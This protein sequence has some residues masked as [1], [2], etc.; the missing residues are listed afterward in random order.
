MK[1]ILFR[2]LGYSLSLIV[3]IVLLN[4]DVSGQTEVAQEMIGNSPFFA[5]YKIYYSLSILIIFGGLL[6]KNASNKLDNNLL[7][8]L[9][10]CLVSIG[11]LYA[12]YN[13]QPD[14]NTTVSYNWFDYF[15][16]I[17]FGSIGVGIYT[18][19]LQKKKIK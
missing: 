10:I 17:F 1:S 2:I 8:K 13:T 3:L 9:L 19:M 7:V 5:S 6:E 11:F 18:Q 14:T 4:I 12:G 15:K 16:M